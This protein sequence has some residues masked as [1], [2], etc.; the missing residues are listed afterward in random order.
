M[1]LRGEIAVDDEFKILLGKNGDAWMLVAD[2]EDGTYLVH[3]HSSHS[4]QN[5][6]WRRD[7]YYV[8]TGK[9]DQCSRCKNVPPDDIAALH[10]W[11]RWK[12]GPLNAC[13]SSL[14][15]LLP[16]RRRGWLRRES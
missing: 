1:T 9:G 5:G 7:W 16:Q 10:G 14:P 13:D 11:A 8:Y 15:R 3:A 4:Y 2:S 12:G 6:V